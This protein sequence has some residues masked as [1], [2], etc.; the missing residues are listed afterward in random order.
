M[1]RQITIIAVMAVMALA[2]CKKAKEAVEQQV[3]EQV[4]NVVNEVD[5]S[6]KVVPALGVLKQL[7][8][9]QEAAKKAQKQ[10]MGKPAGKTVNW[11]AL[12]PFLPDK[13]G[14]FSASGEL[15][16][17]TAGMGQMKVTTVKR[18]YKDGDRKLTVEILDTSLVPVMRAGF[19]MIS[20]FNEDSTEGVKKGIKVEDN[21][22]LLEWRKKRQR[23][24]I[25][26]LVA[27]R[28]LVKATLRPC[29]KPADVVE[30]G[31]LVAIKKLAKVK[32]EEE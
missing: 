30:A 18:V 6:K 22:A 10:L 27:D 31:K 5:P 28:Y 20:T 1:W 14:S 29:E 26:I 4:K 13:L 16:G 25:S 21:P 8:N 15:K 11:R 19:T 9:S 3:S 17:K 2:G 12:A 32:A 23:G 7:V 24:T